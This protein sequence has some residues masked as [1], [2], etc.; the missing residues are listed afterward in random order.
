MK[1]AHIIF[2]EKSK[3]IHGDKFN[4][5]KFMYINAKT[6]GIII[7]PIHG[8]YLQQPCKHT[9]PDSN[10]CKQCWE[11][12]RKK[13]DR[14]YVKK[15]PKSVL[16]FLE[17]AKEK[18]GDKFQY[19]TENYNGMCGNKIKIICPIHGEFNTKPRNHIIKNNVHGCVGCCGDN[20]K[21]LMTHSYDRFLEDSNRKHNNKY[22]YPNNN[23]GIYINKKS[24]ISVICSEHG[25][26]E[27]RA[28]KHTEGQGC[29]KCRLNELINSGV[30]PGGYS[31]ELFKENPDLGSKKAHL[32][33]LSINGGEFYKIGITINDIN[34]RIRGLKCKAGGKIKN[35]SLIAKKE[36]LLYDAFKNEQTIIQDNQESRSYQKWSS[37]VFT[38]NIFNN[39]SKYFN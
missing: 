29:Y 2:L 13:I 35:V 10:G 25:E 8:E 9:L 27:V 12:K 3:Q 6:P 20:F 31:Y 36:M 39:I 26:F 16:F 24:I 5:D 11:L 1:N 32:Y 14:A 7:C 33:Y 15:E 37:E 23:I 4:Y 17:K 18:Y 28:T 22:I 30:F 38:R 34:D 19:D 21:L